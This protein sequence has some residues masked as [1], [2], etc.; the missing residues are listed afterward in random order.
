MYIHKE[1]RILESLSMHYS[2][3]QHH[4]YD[5]SAKTH[6]SNTSMTASTKTEHYRHHKRSFTAETL[7]TLDYTFASNKVD[8]K[9]RNQKADSIKNVP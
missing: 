3:V 1:G 4:N 8:T 7:T 9:C 6:L 2:P 5:L